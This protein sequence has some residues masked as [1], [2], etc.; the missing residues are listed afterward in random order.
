MTVTTIKKLEEAIINQALGINCE[1]EYTVYDQYEDCYTVCLLVDKKWVKPFYK[2]LKAFVE[3]KQ[4]DEFF[5][6]DYGQMNSD[7]ENAKMV[8]VYF[9]DA[10]YPNQIPEIIKIAGKK[11]GLEVEDKPLQGR[12]MLTDGVDFNTNEPFTNKECIVDDYGKYDDDLYTIRYVTK[13]GLDRRAAESLKFINKR[14]KFNLPEGLTWD[15]RNTVLNN[16]TW[17]NPTLIKNGKVTSTKTTTVKAGMEAIAK[18]R[19]EE[20]IW[21]QDKANKYLNSYNKKMELGWTVEL[22][23]YFAKSG[24]RVSKDTTSTI[25]EKE[26]QSTVKPVI[27]NVQAKSKRKYNLPKYVCYDMAESRNRERNVFQVSLYID[28]KLAK[29]NKYSVSSATMWVADKMVAAKKWTIQ[30]AAEYLSTYKPEMENGNFV[31]SNTPKSPCWRKREKNKNIKT[32]KAKITDKLKDVL[33]F[34]KSNDI[35]IDVKVE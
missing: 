23:K 8:C 1:Y 18:N 21:T 28:G 31:P 33:A 2:K 26:I 30:Q 27:E 16:K 34:A 17:F 12:R 3:K 10:I 7:Y 32:I 14:R 5:T 20:G 4:L 29:T 15:T 6:A 35:K 13:G 22:A 24:P 25:K 19:V 11:L 9:N